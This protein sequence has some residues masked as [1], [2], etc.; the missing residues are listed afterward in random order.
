MKNNKD[1]IEAVLMISLI[2]ISGVV[3]HWLYTSFGEVVVY[4]F[5]QWLLSI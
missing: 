3:F 4:G 1:L 2:P 5:Y